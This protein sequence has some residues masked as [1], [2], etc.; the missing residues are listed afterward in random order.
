MCFPYALWFN[1]L[2]QKQKQTNTKTKKITGVD[3]FAALTWLMFLEILLK[4]AFWNTFFFPGAGSINSVLFPV[5]IF[6][7]GILQY[8][9][10]S[11]TLFDILYSYAS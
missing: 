4:P 11:C 7:I 2:K 5:H 6:W 1:T 10:L 8:T 3:Y 9:F